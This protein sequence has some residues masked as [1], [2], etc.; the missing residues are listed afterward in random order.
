MRLKILGIV[1]NFLLGGRDTSLAESGGWFRVVGKSK[2]KAADSESGRSMIKPL[3]VTTLP[4]AWTA[5]E[6]LFISLAV[7]GLFVAVLTAEVVVTNPNT[8]R[9]KRSERTMS[10]S[11]SRN[12]RRL[13]FFESW[14]PLVS[15]GAGPLGGIAV[16]FTLE[17]M[18][19]S[20]ELSS[21]GR[22][23]VLCNFVEEGKSVDPILAL[24]LAVEAVFCVTGLIKKVD[25]G[26]TLDPGV[27]GIVFPREFAE[28]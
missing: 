13:R 21:F 5:G 23:S 9:F 7:C 12:G 28:A 16:L 22:L 11:T 4:C 27:L 6:L 24:F 14:V 18:G 2:S 8:W 25:I 1:F 10:S 15:K 17:G 19:N 26:N 20:D 3:A